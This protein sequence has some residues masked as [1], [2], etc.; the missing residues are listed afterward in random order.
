MLF[1]S[2]IIFVIGTLYPVVNIICKTYSP[3]FFYLCFPSLIVTVDQIQSYNRRNVFVDFHIQYSTIGK[4]Q[5]FR[6][7]QIIREYSGS[8]YKCH[9]FHKFHFI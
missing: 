1:P 5:S 3:S 4:H 9:I 8:I 6:M 2:L 7:I